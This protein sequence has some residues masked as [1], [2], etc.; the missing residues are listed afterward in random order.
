MIHLVTICLSPAMLLSPPAP[1]LST[2][3]FRPP[4]A[5]LR[6]CLSPVPVAVML[7]PPLAYPPRLAPAL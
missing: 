2:G 1:F 5:W 6:C 7:T 4:L 3:R